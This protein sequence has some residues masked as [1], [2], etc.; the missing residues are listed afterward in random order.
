MGTELIV[1]SQKGD[2][3]YQ[4]IQEA[5]DAAE[6][7]GR[8]RVK[9][10]V[11]DESLQI[12][13]SLEILGD[14]AGEVVLR[15]SVENCL[16]VDRGSVVIKR[17]TVQK[18]EDPEEFIAVC[19]LPEGKLQMED[20]VLRSESGAC[21]GVRGEGAQAKLYR[22]RIE[23]GAKEGV[24]VDAEGHVHLQD[25]VLSGF[26]LEPAVGV[27][28][29]GTLEML[30]CRVHDG[31][32]PGLSVERG[33]ALVAESYFADF[34]RS[35]AVFNREGLLDMRESRVD[36]G[37]I[38]GEN[39][40]G[41][42]ADCDLTAREFPC[43]WIDADANPLIRKCRIHDGGDCGL[44]VTE[45]GMGRVED[46]DIYGFHQAPSL[47]IYEGGD[48]KLTR[49][50]FHDSRHVAVAV[51]ERGF[52]TLEACLFEQFGGNELEISEDSNPAVLHCRRIHDGNDVDAADLHR[53]RRTYRTEPKIAGYLPE[54]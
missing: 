31:T 43:I 15:S 53:E 25:C 17:V 44:R 13:K 2:A 27:Y 22:C 29:D 51:T 26:R 21:V 54:G 52:G 33:K 39:G 30:R 12:N 50:V 3:P 37:V 8:I 28:E 19:V 36:G 24:Y 7:G 32:A 46:C 49:C 35:P 48:P 45:N 16:L 5:V 11:Y 1:V 23:N 18:Q 47:W 9:P 40:D 20:C 10:G 42:L 34:V 14:G 4:S 41:V 6:E 38:F